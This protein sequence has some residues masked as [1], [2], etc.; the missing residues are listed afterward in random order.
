[1][2]DR[3]RVTSDEKA[4]RRLRLNVRSQPLPGGRPCHV[5][6]LLF[7]PLGRFVDIYDESSMLLNQPSQHVELPGLFFE[8]EPCCAVLHRRGVPENSSFVVDGVAVDFAHGSL[9]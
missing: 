6:Y 8:N 2:T 4:L 3:V 9:Q 7:D 1:M 5:H